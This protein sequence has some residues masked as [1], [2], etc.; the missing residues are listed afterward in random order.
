M[1]DKPCSYFACKTFFTCI[2]ICSQLILF[3]SM[4]S[5][6]FC[7]TIETSPG[8]QSISFPAINDSTPAAPSGYTADTPFISSPSVIIMPLYP[9]SFLSK[10]V[11]MAGDIDEALF[12]L[13][14]ND[15][16]KRWPTIT[17]PTPASMSLRKVYSSRLSSCVL[18]LL[19]TG[20]AR[21]E[22]TS[23]SP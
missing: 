15:G 17:L 18:V 19:I 9:I 23:T 6:T 1:A 20:N 12:A 22:S 16:I 2:S 14:S 3:C 10:L 21:C 8:R 4:A 7:I 13:L 11:T 5:F